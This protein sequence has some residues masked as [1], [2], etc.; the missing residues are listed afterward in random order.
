MG[1]V[2]C[3]RYIQ[4]ARA[5]PELPPNCRTKPP[6]PAPT[7]PPGQ[8]AGTC[9]EGKKG[10]GKKTWQ[11]NT[12]SPKEFFLSFSF[13]FPHLFA[14]ELL[15]CYCMPTHVWKCSFCLIGQRC[16][17]SSGN[18]C[19]ELHIN[20]WTSLRIALPLPVNSHFPWL[21]EFLKTEFLNGTR[22]GLSVISINAFFSI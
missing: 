1:P 6:R 12:D 2:L 3:W 5:T 10:K 8:P 14:G 21:R 18:Q 4:S 7:Q 15:P 13:T 19:Q 17:I 11:I 22:S 16:Y 20:L 9:N